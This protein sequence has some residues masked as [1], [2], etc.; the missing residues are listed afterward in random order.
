M[1]HE[2]VLVHYCCKT[3][4]LKMSQLKHL[5]FHSFC[6]QGIQMQLLLGASSSGSLTRLQPCCQTGRWPRAKAWLEED[7]FP[8]PSYDY[9]Q[10]SVPCRVLEPQFLSGCSLAIP[11]HVALSTEC[12][13]ILMWFVPQE[14]ACWKL[15]PPVA[16]SGGNGT[17]EEMEPSGRW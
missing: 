3:N 9:W 16:M 6:G 15:G 11:C 14:L 10:S 1:K 17:F 2:F 4:D 5:S 8:S 12:A 13:M 7:L